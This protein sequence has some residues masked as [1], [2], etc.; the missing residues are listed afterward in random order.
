MFVH[1]RTVWVQPDKANSGNSNDHRCLSGL[2]SPDMDDG[3]GGYS[4]RVTAWDRP[5]DDEDCQVNRAASD[6]HGPGIAELE[7]LLRTIESQTF[8]SL[9]SPGHQTMHASN[10]NDGSNTNHGS[11]TNYRSTVRPSIDSVGSQAYSMDFE[12]SFGDTTDAYSDSDSLAGAKRFQPIEDEAE[13]RQ[14]HSPPLVV[15]SGTPGNMADTLQTGASDPK[16]TQNMYVCRPLATFLVQGSGVCTACR[17]ARRVHALCARA[18]MGFLHFCFSSVRHPVIQWWLLINYKLASFRNTLVNA[19]DGKDGRSSPGSV[20]QILQ[21]LESTEVLGHG[22][23]RNGESG[24]DTRQRGQQPNADAPEPV[25]AIHRRDPVPRRKNTI[26]QI[27]TVPPTLRDRA[28]TTT[29]QRH[30]YAEEEEQDIN[31]TLTLNAPSATDAA[32]TTST[33][34]KPTSATYT[35]TNDDIDSHAPASQAPQA[36]IDGNSTNSARH[37]PLSSTLMF[38]SMEPEGTDSRSRSPSPRPPRSPKRSPKSSPRFRR[39]AET[40][41]AFTSSATLQAGSPMPPSSPRNSPRSSP[42]ARRKFQPQPRSGT[43]TTGAESPRG[44]RPPASR[45]DNQPPTGAGLRDNNKGLVDLKA[46]LPTEPPR[47]AMTFTGHEGKVVRAVAFSPLGDRVASGANGGL[48]MV[49]QPSTLP[50]TFF[51]EGHSKDVFA[52]CWNFNATRLASGSGDTTVIVWDMERRVQL[53]DLTLHTGIVRGVAFNCTGDRIIAVSDDQ[54]VSAWDGA[55]QLL[56]QFDDHPTGLRAVACSPV[57]ENRFVTCGADNSVFV[58]DLV[59]KKPILSLEGHTNLV[60]CAAYSRGGDQIVTGSKDCRGIVW[61]ATTG[62]ILHDLTGHRGAVQAVAFA[63][64]GDG[65]MTGSSDK[66]AMLWSK[67]SD[68]PL[69]TL[70]GHNSQV[71]G[72]SFSPLGDRLA[73]S[74]ADGTVVVWDSTFSLAATKVGDAL[75]PGATGLFLDKCGLQTIPQNILDMP[76]NKHW[77]CIDLSHN[78]LADVGPLVQMLEKLPSVKEVRLQGNPI[79]PAHVRKICEASPNCY[80]E[81]VKAFLGFTDLHVYAAM[82]D[83]ANLAAMLNSGVDQSA[84]DSQTKSSGKDTALSLA[85]AGF[86]LPCVNMLIQAGASLQTTLGV[87]ESKKASIAGRFLVRAVFLPSLKL[88]DSELVEVN[89]DHLNAALANL[90]STPLLAE[91]LVDAANKVVNSFHQPSCDQAEC[92][93]YA[94]H[95]KRLLL[96]SLEK[97]ESGRHTVDVSQPLSVQIKAIKDYLRDYVWAPLQF[98]SEAVAKSEA[99]NSFRRVVFNPALDLFRQHVRATALRTVDSAAMYREMIEDLSREDRTIY[100]QQ[101]S[102]SKKGAGGE[103]YA[104]VLALINEAENAVAAAKRPPARQLTADPLDLTVAVRFT[105]P[106]FVEIVD[107]AVRAAGTKDIDSFYRRHT[108]AV[109]RIVEKGVLKHSKERLHHDGP[110]DC[111]SILD[112]GGCLLDCETY[113]SMY[114][115]ITQI[116]EFDRA[117]KWT[118]CR[119]KNRWSYPSDG[120]WRDCMINV[121]VDGVVF[122]I[123]VVLGSLLD[124]RSVLKGHA[125]YGKVRCFTELLLLEGLDASVEHQSDSQKVSQLTNQ[126]EQKEQTVHALKSGFQAENDA[127]KDELLAQRLELEALKAMMLNA[128]AVNSAGHSAEPESSHFSSSI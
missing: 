104:G 21:S 10:T 65:V 57:D 110:V 54:M 46:I 38:I 102:K 56:H 76:V 108:K 29:S 98:C 3:G 78:S 103:Q 112:V 7:N 9:A 22:D 126:L 12:A 30:A 44:R 41:T 52:L 77:T 94:Q 35:I 49:W 86:F 95:A 45:P 100:E 115:I 88:E 96:Q 101:F 23:D 64:F 5:S 70:E 26:N 72:V 42:R 17:H 79:Q 80:A 6:G 34:T 40:T 122:E 99:I 71:L 18:K 48:I 90:K 113:A 128:T 33:P 92:N 59:E 51:L 62:S 14:G 16:R 91:W 67:S 116:V 15:N 106:H 85:A 89:Q 53:F 43:D 125:Q 55:G 68:T 82:G 107:D 25:D 75:K 83:D 120:G 74:S 13:A 4:G 105:T 1:S 69:V 73:T 81:L 39:K 8:E 84:L 124:A 93:E 97:N 109:Y 58:W 66:S 2:E 127:L 37:D 47:K 61:D 118:I 50:D 24:G 27:S 63:S 11:N 20:D 119:I 111:S 60:F 117:Q 32:T 114:N 121:I 87:L 123:Q 19:E 31:T 28:T 36:S